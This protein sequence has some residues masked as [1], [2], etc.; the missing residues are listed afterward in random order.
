MACDLSSVRKTRDML[1]STIAQRRAGDFS[2]CSEMPMKYG[3]PRR[4]T[5]CVI[6]ARALSA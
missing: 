5:F 1:H 2:E 6:A 3:F 4:L